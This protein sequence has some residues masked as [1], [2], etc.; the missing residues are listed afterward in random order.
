MYMRLLLFCICLYTVSAYPAWFEEYKKSYA[1][2]YNEEDEHRAYHILKLKREHIRGFRD[3]SVVLKLN[4]ESDINRTKHANKHILRN[5]RRRWTEYYKANH[6]LGTPSHFDWR[7]HHYVTSPKRQ[8]KCG[9]CFAFAATGHLE[10]WFKKKTGTLRE[11]S[12]QQALDCSKP[13]S[14]G[15]EGGLMEDVYYH[16]WSNPIGPVSFDRWKGGDSTCRHRYRHP[17]VKVHKYVSM[18]SD[19]HDPVESHLARN[20]HTYGPIPVAVDSTSRAFDLY[21]DGILRKEHCGNDVDHAVLVV[22]YTPEYWIVK[23][24]W[25][26]H[27]GQNGY[28]YIERGRNACGIDTYA[29]F[30]TQVSI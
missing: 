3:S 22:G 27:W 13:E 12:I 29:S 14:D 15:C 28:I 11:L 1:K 18:S 26:S 19:Y 5:R 4:S 24:S 20:I 6:K 21:H 10:F 25:G 30:A 7:A 17:Y 16:S 9:G 2:R 23:N 8:G